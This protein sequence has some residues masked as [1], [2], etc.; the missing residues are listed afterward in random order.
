MRR[1]QENY[2]LFVVLLYWQATDQEFYTI[3]NI[4][5]N[6]FNVKYFVTL[7][8]STT[9]QVM[10]HIINCG[11]IRKCGR[12][13]MDD[14]ILGL[15]TISIRKAISHKLFCP[16]LLLSSVLSLESVRLLK[17][18]LNRRSAFCFSLFDFILLK[19]S[20]IFYC[21]MILFIKSFLVISEF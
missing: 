9:S 13:R 18:C 4:F 2:K 8:M 12:I 20:V 21:A 11:R 1:K 19:S 10:V 17:I 6:P 3:C 14:K 5:F 16:S 7:D 15:D